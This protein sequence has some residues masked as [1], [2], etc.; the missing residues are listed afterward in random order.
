LL[1]RSK[2]NCVEKVAQVLPDPKVDTMIAI[3]D[4]D[5]AKR[6]FPPRAYEKAYVQTIGARSSVEGS[7]RRKR[8]SFDVN[9]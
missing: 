4:N 7:T 1:V 5:I 9:R 8:I 6:R 3:T 2:S